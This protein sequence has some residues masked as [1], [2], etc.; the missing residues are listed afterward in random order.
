MMSAELVIE[1]PALPNSLNPWTELGGVA[2]PETV[3]GRG[4]KKE[5]E[6]GAP[7]SRSGLNVLYNVFTST[8]VGRKYS[9][10]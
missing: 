9:A 8:D 1:V 10:L 7:T 3:P 6:C 4:I 5:R 2:C